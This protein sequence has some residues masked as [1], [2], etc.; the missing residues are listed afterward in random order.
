[1]MKDVG[2]ILNISTRTVA[3]HK[4]RIMEILGLRSNADLARYA[5]REHLIV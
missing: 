4:Y 5:I 2:S 3:F 1:M